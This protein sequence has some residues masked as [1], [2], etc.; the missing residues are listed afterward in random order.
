MHLPNSAR[1]QNIEAFLSEFSPEQPGVLDFSMHDRWVAV[2]PA[3]LAFTA[4]VADMV[5]RN[6]GEHRGEVHNIRSV[7]YLIRMGLFDHVCIPHHISITAHEEAGRFI[8]LSRISTSR[9]LSDFIVHM[10][11]LLHAQPQQVEPI[12]YVISEIVRNVLE[13]AQCPGGAFLCAQYFRSSGILSIGVADAGIGIQHTMSQCH[14]VPTA[15]DALVLALTP[16]YSGTTS[17]IGGTAYNAGAGLFFTKSI[18]CASRNYF[19]LY[20]GNALFKLKPIR[21]GRQVVLYANPLEDHH[22]KRVNMPE[23]QGTLVGIDIQ[24]ETDIMFAALMGAIREAYSV[25]VKRKKDEYK[26]PT[27]V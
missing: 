10:I 23:W 12:R 19:I 6:G 26:R 14:R 5:T 1:L 9:E 21:A 15:W 13:H 18:A 3:V 4:S 2:H 11:P 17:R 22:T 16:G 24:L 8:P 20:S 7:P 27:F 25:D